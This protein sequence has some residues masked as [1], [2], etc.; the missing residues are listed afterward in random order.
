M[1]KILNISTLLFICLLYAPA[2][3][4]HDSRKTDD[5]TTNDHSHYHSPP[6][7]YAYYAEN[8]KFCRYN[9]LYWSTEKDCQDEPF[10]EEPNPKKYKN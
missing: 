9:K 2:S 5:C 4:A 7:N 6:V 8:D 3:Q 10:K 1:K